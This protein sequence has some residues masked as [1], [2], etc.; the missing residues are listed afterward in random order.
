VRSTPHG[1]ALHL[2]LNDLVDLARLEAGHEHRQLASFDAAR[3]VREL[4]ATFKPLADERSL[5]LH[6]EGADTLQVEGD[7]VKLQ[8]IAQNLILNALHYTDRG[9]VRRGRCG[10]V[11]RQT[12]LRASGCDI[13]A[14]DKARPRHHIS[15]EFPALL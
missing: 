7:P 2:L 13:G 14:R 11:Y 8:R 9:G 15:R 10:I 1:G 4:G 12:H 6:A 5:F 3:V